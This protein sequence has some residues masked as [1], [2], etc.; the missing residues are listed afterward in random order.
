MFTGVS[1]FAGGV[2]KSAT[3]PIRA[4]RI[5]VVKHE[6]VLHL[7]DGERWVKSYRIGLG[8]SPEGP[9]SH[10]GDGQTPL[11]KFYICSRN[12]ASRYHRFLGISYPDE[13]AVRRGLAEGLISQGQ[14][15]AIRTALREWRQP[16]WTTPLGGGIGLHGGGNDRDWTAGCIAL[17]DQAIDELDAVMR[18]GDPVEILP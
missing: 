18:L 5:V 9:G 11:G 14:A 13:A 15:E 1:A 6:R 4:P 2:T 10:P 17:T 16:D 3:S 7:F 12:R 8:R